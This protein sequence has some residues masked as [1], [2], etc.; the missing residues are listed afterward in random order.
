MARGTKSIS[1]HISKNLRRNADAGKLDYIQNN[2]GLPCE[3]EKELWN[4]RYTQSRHTR[5]PDLI[6]NKRVILEHDTYKIHGDLNAPT[7]A[8][9][10]RNVDHCLGDL[11]WCVINA[12]LAR[13]LGLDE[14]K[15]ANYLYYH[16]LCQEQARKKALELLAY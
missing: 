9:L 7:E 15:L 8:T 16:T 5:T 13:Q 4:V 3:R 11:P 1:H 14:A 12:G 2:I 10:K 6:I